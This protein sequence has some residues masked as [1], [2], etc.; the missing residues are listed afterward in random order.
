MRPL[1]E[2]ET[3]AVFESKFMSVKAVQL[4]ELNLGVPLLQSLPITL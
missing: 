3:K 1:T 4:D 2:E